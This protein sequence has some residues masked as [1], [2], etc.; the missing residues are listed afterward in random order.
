[1]SGSLMAEE[2]GGLTHQSIVLLVC[3]AASLQ[4]HCKICFDLMNMGPA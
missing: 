4:D 3:E 2:C 1:M